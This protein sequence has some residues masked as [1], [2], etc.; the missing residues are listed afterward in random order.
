M[1]K[2][3]IT[4]DIVSDVACPWCYVGKRRLEEALQQWEGTP[5]KVQWHPYQLD[6]TIPQ[7]GLDRDTYLVNKFGNLE[8][9]RAMTDRLTAVGEAVAINFDFGKNWLAVNTLPMHQLLH[10]AGKE[11]FQNELKERFF[12]AYFVESL[13]LNTVAVFSE[14]MAEFGW[15]SEKVQ[16][17]INDETIAKTVQHEIAHYQQMGVT[18]VPFFIINNT[19]GISGAQPSSTFLEAFASVAPLEITAEGDRCDPSNENC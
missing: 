9:T 4:V 13:H 19:Y 15:S 3:V 10:I 14:I 1:T 11:G 7:K 12:R 8:R 6:P 16:R 2:E 17:I 18:G 5:I